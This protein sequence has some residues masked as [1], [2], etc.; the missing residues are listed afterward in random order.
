[1]G[2]AEDRRRPAAPALVVF[3]RERAANQRGHLQSLKEL[4]AHPNAFRVAGLAAGGQVESLR[5][6][7]EH[8]RKALLVVANLLPE[9]KGELGV[10]PFKAAGRPVTIG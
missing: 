9:R 3:H 2:I 7:G 10:A 8:A 6:P 1:E 4:A 5:G